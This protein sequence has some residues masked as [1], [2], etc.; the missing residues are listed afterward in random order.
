MMPLLEDVPGDDGLAG[1]DV[2]ML[3]QDTP[4]VDGLV[5]VRITTGSVRLGGWGCWCVRTAGPARRGDGSVR[6]VTCPAGC[7]FPLGACCQ[8]SA[9]ALSGG[10]RSAMDTALD[11][12]GEL[13]QRVTLRPDL[14]RRSR[15]GRAP[16]RRCSS[17]M[18]SV[19]GPGGRSAGPARGQRLVPQAPANGPNG[20]P[21]WPPSLTL[22]PPRRG[23]RVLCR[24]RAERIPTMRRDRPIADSMTQGED[25]D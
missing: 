21:G 24:R 3:Q 19:A 16:A 11:A 18:S 15:P 8:F 20:A 17:S 25:D 1:H 4:S 14:R 2:V 9:S 7:V 13:M 5:A 10:V 6:E 22:P 12:A 23:G